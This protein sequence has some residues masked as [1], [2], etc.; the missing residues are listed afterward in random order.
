MAIDFYD[1]NT[2]SSGFAGWR[3]AGYVRGK[4]YQKYF[5]LRNPHPLID[6]DVWREYQHLRARYFEAKIMARSAACK[7]IDFVSTTNI[8]TL[9]CRGLGFQGMTMAIL[10]SPGTQRYYCQFVINNQGKTQRFP[11][12]A[13]Q[14][15]EQAWELAIDA[16]V[17]TYDIRPKDAAVIRHRK[18]PNPAAFKTL[19]QQMNLHEGHN[20]PVDALHFVFA[21]QREDLQRQRAIQSFLKPRSSLS[22]KNLGAVELTD[23]STSLLS[24]IERY[25]CN[26]PRPDSS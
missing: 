23:F 12:R 14:S 24:E 1:S 13:D 25:R 7:Y 21:G 18:K 3:V 17:S 22:E 20:I 11:N 19:R 6:D 10:P 2:L 5:P 9:P 26:T 4:R 15:F 16:W 8:R